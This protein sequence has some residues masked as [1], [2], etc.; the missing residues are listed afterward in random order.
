MSGDAYR[1]MVSG[2]DP[3][4]F[5]YRPPP[6]FSYFVNP[7]RLKFALLKLAAPNRVT[8]FGAARSRFTGFPLSGCVVSV[9]SLIR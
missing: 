5:S 9:G 3:A 1:E 7:I 2:P 4:V 8:A 6:A